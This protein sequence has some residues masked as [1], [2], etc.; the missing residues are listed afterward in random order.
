MSSS[1]SRYDEGAMTPPRATVQGLAVV[2][3]TARPLPA[4]HLREDLGE[5]EEVLKQRID[6]FRLARLRQEVI[7]EEM[8]LEM[9]QYEAII[10]APQHARLQEM[11]TEVL[12]EAARQGP[13]PN[14]VPAPIVQSPPN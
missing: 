1:N 11:A 4:A 3:Q 2:V 8:K 12:R 9:A 13:A 14:V 10:I 6:A 7:N 5:E